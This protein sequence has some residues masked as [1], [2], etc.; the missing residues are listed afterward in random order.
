MPQRTRV[1]A[2]RRAATGPSVV[3]PGD[4]GSTGAA[5]PTRPDDGSGTSREQRALAQRK[6]RVYTVAT[7]A[8]ALALGLSWLTREP[9]DVLLAYGYPSALL[10][11]LALTLGLLL[12]RVSIH[13]FERTIYAAM[14]AL[15]L[16]RLAWHLHLAGPIDEHLLVL[17][18]GHYWAVGVLLVAGFVLL[19]RRVGLLTG[20]AVI[21]LS[22][23]LVAT[24]AGPQLV[25]PEGARLELLYLARVHGFLVV[26]LAL[27]TAVATMREQLDRSLARAEAF[28]E[29]ASTDQLTGLANRR[30]ALEVLDRE[31]QAARRYGRPLAIVLAD[32][33]HF[34]RVNDV[35]GHGVGDQVLVEVAS[36]LRRH[37]RDADVVAR[38]GGEEFLIVAPEVG[39]T[40]AST[41]AER[42][43]TAIA[44]LRPAGLHASATFGVAELRAG[45]DLDALLQ[46][47]DHHLYQGKRAGRDRVVGEPGPA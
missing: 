23:L 39:Q 45:E 6:R 29:L 24:G 14:A 18:G 16:G 22:L 28:E 17:A 37:A 26:L 25:G 5:T 46:R 34:K 35:H 10:L 38:W 2:G 47:A 44:A 30:A 3:P 27:T 43:R 19:D 21:V 9:G 15:I 31:L 40:G 7:L 8:A 12:R 20:V 33:D 36:E 13:V 41:L 1:P 32:I 11:L 4:G 42:C